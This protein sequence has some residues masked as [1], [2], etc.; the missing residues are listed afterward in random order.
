MS[1][2][3]NANFSSD[4]FVVSGG[5][6]QGG[7]LCLYSDGLLTEF[8]VGC[9]NPLQFQLTIFSSFAIVVG[10]Y[11]TGFT[12]ESNHAFG[13]CAI[14]TR[15]LVVTRLDTLSSHRSSRIGQPTM[16]EDSDSDGR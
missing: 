3:W 9:L 5:V 10:R 11:L 4:S 16:A 15:T 12:A 2:Q 6:L 8:G 7:E 14:T 1:V 13:A